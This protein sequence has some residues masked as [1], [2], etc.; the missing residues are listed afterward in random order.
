MWVDL[1]GIMLSEISQTERDKFVC[2]H[3][4]GESKKAKFIETGSR[5]AVNRSW[6]VRE[7]ERCC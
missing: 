7:L 4:H 5:I 3:F 6:R 1:E 2:S